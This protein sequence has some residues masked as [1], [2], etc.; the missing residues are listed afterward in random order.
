MYIMM[1]TY[2]YIYIKYRLRRKTANPG[3]AFA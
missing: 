2:N 3:D 1:Y